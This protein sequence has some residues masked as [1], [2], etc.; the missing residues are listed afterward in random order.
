MVGALLRCISPLFVIFRLFSSLAG[1]FGFSCYG[2]ARW[3]RTGE[4]V[5]GLVFAYGK[6]AS[7]GVF[8]PAE[9]GGVLA[10]GAGGLLRPLSHSWQAAVS[11]R[12]DTG[13]GQLRMRSYHSTVSPGYGCRRPHDVLPVKLLLLS[14]MM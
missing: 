14:A 13:T 12:P 3:G 5:G 8:F 7:G 11:V 1:R 9:S 4:A 6:V 10:D 2:G